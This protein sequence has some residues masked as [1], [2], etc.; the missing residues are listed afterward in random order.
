N[1]NSRAQNVS[2][3]TTHEDRELAW[4]AAWKDR[5]V[6]SEGGHNDYTIENEDY[7]QK[8]TRYIYSTTA[9]YFVSPVSGEYVVGSPLSGYIHLKLPESPSLSPTSTR[10]IISVKIKAPEARTKPFIKSL[11]TN[12]VKL[13]GLVIEH[14]ALLAAGGDGIV[15]VVFETNETIEE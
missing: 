13:T 9:F 11:T 10:K 6:A 7:G 1:T 4:G 8:N 12:G 5:R 2:G 14:E 3:L 15:N